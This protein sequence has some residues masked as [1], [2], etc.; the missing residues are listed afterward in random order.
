VIERTLLQEWA[1]RHLRTDP[2]LSTV[3]AADR[4]ALVSEYQELDRAL[5]AA[6]T[7]S[8][9][10]ACNARRPRCD[11]GEAADPW[12]GSSQCT[13]GCGSRAAGL[14]WWHSGWFTRGGPG[15][16]AAAG[17]LC[18]TSAQAVLRS[19]RSD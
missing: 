13:S 9:I 15:A 5:I 7:G 8:I 16:G 10:R 14:T 2:D 12:G 19:L 4:D 18:A 17:A 11:F 3:R 1:E 6:A